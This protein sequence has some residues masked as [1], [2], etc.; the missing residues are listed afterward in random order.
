MPSH[1]SKR[2]LLVVCEPDDATRES[3]CDRLTGDRLNT[4]PASTASDALRLCRSNEPNLMVLDI[5]LPGA[6]GLGALRQIRQAADAG[7]FDPRLPI[8]A[9]GERVA[10]TDRVRWLEEGADDFISKPASYEELRARIAAL[11]RRTEGQEETPIT[12]GDLMIDAARRLVYVG[13]RE[14]HVTNRE[15]TLLQMIATDPTRVFSRDEL[16][17]AIPNRKR[18]ANA[19]RAVDSHLSRL[20]GKLDPDQKRYV[21]NCWG[22]GYSLVSA[23]IGEVER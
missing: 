5:A 10:Q 20:R 18:S 13:E 16:L 4:L 23:G 1:V 12:I 9:V 17:A 6:S 7:E 3:L 21:V 15:F 14:V 8:I 19:T 22:I 2:P 11:L